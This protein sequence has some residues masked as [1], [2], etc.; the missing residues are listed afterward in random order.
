MFVNNGDRVSKM[1]RVLEM[2]RLHQYKHLSLFFEEEQFQ[3][4]PGLLRNFPADGFIFTLSSLCAPTVM[5]LEQAGIPFVSTDGWPQPCQINSVGVDN[6]LAIC[7]ML[8]RLKANGH[9]RVAFFNSPRTAEYQFF[10]EQIRESFEKVFG[11]DFCP[12]MFMTDINAA[13]CEFSK[14]HYLEEASREYLRRCARMP[15]P[16]TAFLLIDQWCGCIRNIL[17]DN[18][19]D[20]PGELSVA[21]SLRYSEPEDFS[22]AIFDG[23]EICCAALEQLF[24]LLE[25]PGAEKIGQLIPP[26]F[27]EGKII[28]PAVPPDFKKWRKLR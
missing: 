24:K 26:R 22:A 12:E 14:D 10:L 21:C 1:P 27:L 4:N 18:G 15:E 20:I 17:V 7:T 9:R 13:E 6:R 16:P 2:L 23:E 8:E 3:N 5:H 28:A 25:N 11:D 19:F